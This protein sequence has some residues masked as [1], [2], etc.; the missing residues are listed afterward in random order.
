M[1]CFEIIKNEKTLLQMGRCHDEPL[2]LAL[3]EEYL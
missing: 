1:D 3:L 2:T